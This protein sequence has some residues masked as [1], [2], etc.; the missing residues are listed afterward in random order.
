MDASRLAESCRVLLA[1]FDRAGVKP[2]AEQTVLDARSTVD[3]GRRLQSDPREVRNV[4]DVLAST[5]DGAIPIRIY[6]ADETGTG[7]TIVYFHG[8]GWV[9]GGIEASDVLCR[10]LATDAGGT[11][12]SV[13]YR[14]SPETQ[15]PGPLEDCYAATC[16][17]ASGGGGQSPQKPLVVCGDSAG[18]NLATATVLLSRVRNGPSIAYQVLIYPALTPEA[19]G[20]EPQRVGSSYGLSRRDMDWFWR[21]YLGERSADS[22]AAPLLAEGL[23]GMPPTLLVV[24]EFDPLREEGMAYAGE[25]RAAGAQVEVVVVPGV[26]HGFLSMDKAVPEAGP[27]IERVG[28]WI[29]RSTAGEHVIA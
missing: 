26:I 18:G 17:L 21:H 8:G 16:W 11:V 15:Y 27:V 2:Y 6:V 22:F 3:A 7:P 5:S 23:T 24:A 12:A 19:A 9:T 10:Q 25:L 13:G 14:L 4:Y 1:R 29:A 28:R 20:F